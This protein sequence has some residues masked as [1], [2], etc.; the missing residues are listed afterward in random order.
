[1]RQNLRL[2]LRATYGFLFLVLVSLLSVSVGRSQITVI[3]DALPQVAMPFAGDPR[4]EPIPD[5]PIQLVDF[6]VSANI[7]DGNGGFAP[8]IVTMRFPPRVNGQSFSDGD[9]HADLYVLFDAATGAPIDQPPIL[10]AVPKNAAGPLV[11]VD[12]ATAYKYSAIWELH[13][14]T[15]DATYNSADLTTRID[16]ETK[17]FS[18]PH[19]QKI[20]QTNIF[21][22]CPV[23][24]VGSVVQGNTHPVE[25]AFWNGNIVNIVPYDIED[26]PFNAQ[27]LFKFEDQAGNTLPD[28]NN[29]YLVASHAPGEPFYSS[30]WELWTV[31][32]PPG[33]EGNITNLKTKA[34]VNNSG[35]QIKSG[36]I[37]LNCPAVAVNGVPIPAEDFR[38]VLEDQNGLW[39]PA[40]FPKD[41]PDGQF[42]RQRS[43]VITEITPGGL[44]LPAGALGSTVLPPVDPLGKGNVIPLLLADPFQTNTSGPNSA[45]PILRINQGELDAAYNGGVNPQLPPQFEANFTALINAGLLAP[46]WGLGGG[47]S[48]QERL[49]LL[50]RALFELIWTPEQ[51]AHSNDVTA[52]IACHSM[53]AAGGAA[54]GLYTLDRA[55]PL[56]PDFGL[57]TH[58]NAGSMFGSGSAELLNA[59]H[60]ALPNETNLITFA[61]GSQ[62]QIANIRGVVAGANN[63]HMGIQAVESLIT[64]PAAIAKCGAPGETQLTIAEAQNCDLD[65]DGVVNE[66]TVGEVTAETVFLMTLPI[67]APDRTPQTLTLLGI[68]GPS[69]NRGNS[70]FTGSVDRG[71]AACGSCHTPFTTFTNN[72]VPTFLLSN[73]ETSSQLPLILTHTVLAN[74]T[75]GLQLYGDFKKH[76]MGKL[77]LNNSSDTAKTAELWDVGSVAPYLRDGSAGSS[78]KAAI[79]A[80]G[81]VSL[82]GIAVT[83]DPQV[84]FANTA[85]KQFSS[86]LITI[87]NISQN[88]IDLS[89]TVP[90]GSKPG[91]LPHFPLR[92]ILTGTITPRV[93]AYKPTG[94]GVGRSSRQGAFWVV[95]NPVGDS[96]P[97]GGSVTV[98]LTFSNPNWQ[99]LQY[100]L[101]VQD[102][103]GYSE[104]AASADAFQALTPSAQQD[105]VNFLR[106]QLIQ[107]KVGEGSGGH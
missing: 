32:V 7:P 13:A 49:A 23:V 97:P 87:T 43:F 74:G 37:R 3:P 28:P 58:L 88:P 64:N 36:N 51:G 35:F 67:P 61:H 30:I 9:R 103:V 91:T 33:Q 71:G 57:V 2:G 99:V 72:N 50:G 5:G 10:E 85:G 11:S 102:N 17:V 100:G 44:G 84:N 45:G 60:K 41:F 98:N 16:S 25:D 82:S 34:D 15:V 63:A 53:P 81:G 105:L 26:G 77:M 42:T 8:G 48:Y 69:V 70:R 56:R 94:L 18:S 21:L 4:L 59:Q 19:V 47:R 95:P 55:N 20:F 106:V 31:V 12:D 92:V 27:V 62:G 29:P 101:L 75:R 93:Q 39:N 83:R 52:C 89:T 90:A 65:S 68:T 80:H 76:K 24:P 38:S 66:L 54:R 104:A 6:P 107:G 40:A 1:M 78:L 22:N 86:Q 46:E 79:L 14:V 73:P 96:I